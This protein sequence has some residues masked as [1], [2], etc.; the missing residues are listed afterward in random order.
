MAITNKDIVKKVNDAFGRNDIEAFLDQCTDSVVWTMIGEQPL[1]GKDEIRAFTASM[2]E[3]APQIT[4][5]NMIEEG[6]LVVCEG[7]VQM[8][9]P[10]GTDYHGAFCDIYRFQDGKIAK[11]DFY[12]VDLK[13][14]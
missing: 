5:G 9:N 2:P 8:K 10:D 11:L 12:V 13:T 6:N 4:L 14:K 7:T 3:S 1:N